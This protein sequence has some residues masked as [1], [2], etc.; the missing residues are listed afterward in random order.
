MITVLTLWL[1]PGTH[2]LCDNFDDD[3]LLANLLEFQ[4][5]LVIKKE[6]HVSD[7]DSWWLESIFTFY[8]CYDMALFFPAS[9]LMDSIE[10]PILFSLSHQQV[11]K[12]L[13]DMQV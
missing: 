10:I 2:S 9:S 3:V 7:K 13:V 8:Y 5:F 11:C 1:C 12:T 4:K 6:L